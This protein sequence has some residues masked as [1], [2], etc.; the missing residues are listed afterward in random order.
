MSKLPLR[1]F[2][3]G[4]IRTYGCSAAALGEGQFSLAFFRV[5]FC[6]IFN[7]VVERCKWGYACATRL[8]EANS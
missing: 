7:I 5:S 6:V 8:H 4:K 3:A 1:V 2:N